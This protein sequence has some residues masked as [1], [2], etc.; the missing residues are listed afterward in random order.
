MGSWGLEPCMYSTCM[1]VCMDVWMDGWMDVLDVLRN[2]KLQEVQ[3]NIKTGQQPCERG[4]G[5]A[6]PL[7]FATATGQF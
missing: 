4:S 7:A 6:I 3:C 1:D 5:H 2:N